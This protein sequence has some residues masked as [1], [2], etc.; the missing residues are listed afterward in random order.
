[1]LYRHPGV[2]IITIFVP[3]WI[4]G[5]ITLMIFFMSESFDNRIINTA[6]V[7]ISFATYFQVIRSVLPKSSHI[8]L[9]EIFVYCIISICI[10]AIGETMIMRS[11][12]SIIE[13]H[14][15]ERVLFMISF[16]IEVISFLMVSG[17]LLFHLLILKP[18][19]NKV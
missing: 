16:L 12:P 9:M 2:S 6:T 4:L 11:N 7:Y 5:L 19:Y 1:M 8:S 13:I 18:S 14:P 3:M 17:G 15:F 10:F